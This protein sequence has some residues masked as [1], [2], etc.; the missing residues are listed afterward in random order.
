MNDC[1]ME[2]MAGCGIDR[3]R[4]ESEA[5][6][7]DW[8]MEADQFIEALTFGGMKV[9]GQWFRA[10]VHSCGDNCLS[11]ADRLQTLAAH[12]IAQGHTEFGAS[13]AGLSYII[14]TGLQYGKAH[15]IMVPFVKAKGNMLSYYEEDVA[16]LGRFLSSNPAAV[17]ALAYWSQQVENNTKARQAQEPPAVVQH[18]SHE[19]TEENAETSLPDP[20]ELSA[21]YPTIKS[22]GTT[23]DD[24]MFQCED[25]EAQAAEWQFWIALASAEVFVKDMWQNTKYV[26]NG[27]L[28]VNAQPGKKSPGQVVVKSKYGTVTWVPKTKRLYI[29]KGGAAFKERLGKAFPVHSPAPKNDAKRS[30]YSY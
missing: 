26:K 30:R 15:G 20:A 7:I 12:L 29:N 16:E 3:G 10:L 1:G 13:A 6:I 22:A 25:H 24:L 4:G 18:T 8:G 14:R 17:A 11:A 27:Q 5:P 28:E 19:R 23:G 2:E 21:V 9:V